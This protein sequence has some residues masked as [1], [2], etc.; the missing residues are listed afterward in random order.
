MAGSWIASRTMGHV[1][2]VGQGML[3]ESSIRAHQRS[4]TRVAYV[5]GFS[6]H[7][8]P[9]Q[10][11]FAV[12]PAFIFPNRFARDPLTH[13][14]S[15]FLKHSW[16]GFREIVFWSCSSATAAGPWGHSGMIQAEQLHKGAAGQGGPTYVQVNTAVESVRTQLEEA[17]GKAGVRR[18]HRFCKPREV[19]LL[20]CDIVTRVRTYLYIMA[21]EVALRSVCV[22]CC[23]G[24]R[25]KAP[26]PGLRRS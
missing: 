10:R 5:W 22:A 3:A 21:H 8:V 15:D 9:C 19:W 14:S 13:D 4:G 20:S 17:T 12:D 2:L 25:S 23:L 16:I 18:K 1:R 6:G 26:R 24:P 7:R 11:V